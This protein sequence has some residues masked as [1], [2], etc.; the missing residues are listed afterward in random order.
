[1]EGPDHPAPEA[2]GVIPRAVRRIFETSH[3]MEAKGWQNQEW[4]LGLLGLF[5][6]PRP[7]P[8]TQYQFTANF[9]EIYNESLRDL[10][11]LR[12]EQNGELEIRRVSQFTEELHVPNLSCV[13]V[14]SEE[15]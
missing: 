9:L 15:E 3:E 5:S 6:E 1:M 2:A 10:L 8:P 12:P 7:S 4:T 13:P 14:S 11:V